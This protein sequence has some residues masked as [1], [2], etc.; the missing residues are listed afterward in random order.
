MMEVP[1]MKTQNRT[2][3][4]SKNGVA[5]IIVLGLL[6]VLTLIAVAFAI[7]MRVERLAA[8]N[9]VNNI[10]AE[11]MVQAGIVRAMETI[12]VTLSTNC[13]PDWFKFAP[14]NTHDALASY[15]G[16]MPT[17]GTNPPLISAEAI[18]AAFDNIIGNEPLSFQNAQD[19]TLHL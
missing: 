10:R 8:R 13:Y 2:Y 7:A 14:A 15:D 12:D 9:Y 3:S 17:V 18:N 5:L 6:A 16:T 1:K 19:L 11:Q 4:R